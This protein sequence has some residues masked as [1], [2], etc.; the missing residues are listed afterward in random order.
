MIIIIA[1]FYLNKYFLSANFYCFPATL[2]SFFI[3]FRIIRLV[4]QRHFSILGKKTLHLSLF[5]RIMK[6]ISRAVKARFLSQ[7]T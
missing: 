2:A 3:S 7:V 4:P 1:P 5:S 6:I